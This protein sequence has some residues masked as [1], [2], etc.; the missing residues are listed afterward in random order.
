VTCGEMHEDE[1]C[2]K[3]RRKVKEDKDT[4]A[5]IRKRSTQKEGKQIHVSTFTSS[6]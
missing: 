2:G 5:W 1:E 6:T 3:K 4:K